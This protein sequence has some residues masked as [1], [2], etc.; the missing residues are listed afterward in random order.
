MK[1]SAR[2]VPA[3][4]LSVAEREL[5]DGLQATNHDL[6]TAFLSHRYVTAA[7]SVFPHVRVC[8][9]ER[10][11]QPVGF[12]PFQFRHSWHRPLGWGERVGGELSDYFGVI[13]PPGLGLSP[14][15]LLKL[16]GLTSLAFTHLPQSQLSR[17]LAG[18]Q[19]EKG[20]RIVIGGNYWQ[21]LRQRDKRFV[22]DTERRERKLADAKGPLRFVFH[23]TGLDQ[24]IAAKRAQ[25]DRTGV[26]DPLAD[27]KAVRFLAKLAKISHPSCQGV[28]STLMAGDHW[29]ASH[30]GLRHGDTLHY[31][32][33]VYNPEFQP[34]SPGRLLVKAIIQCEAGIRLIDRGAGDTPAKRDFANDEHVLTRGLWQTPSARALA[35]RVGLAVKWRLAHSP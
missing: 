26:G 32:F 13:A 14:G 21:D 22:V 8:I 31:W 6:A 19:P 25:Y 27:S 2:V 4:A 23:D 29:V 17:G 5:W 7:A 15:R 34:F 12:F 28:L 24:L 9:L 11:G 30:F 20:L 16:A 33:P 10:S 35:C 1:L 18:E 3:A